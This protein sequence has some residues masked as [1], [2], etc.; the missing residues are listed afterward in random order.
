[1]LHRG[2]YIRDFIK[3]AFEKRPF[4]AYENNNPTKTIMMITP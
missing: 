4:L 2:F 1:M 3:R